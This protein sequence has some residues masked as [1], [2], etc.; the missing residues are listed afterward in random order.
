M[1]T[2]A[3]VVRKL[4]DPRAFAAA[5]LAR[6]LPAHPR[7]GH[8]WLHRPDGAVTFREHGFVAAD[9]P[10][11]LLVRHNYETERIRAELDGKR[12][13]RSL[14]LGCGFGR[15]SMTIAAFSDNHLAADI[16]EGA[17][18]LARS[19]YPH[20]NFQEVRP[21]DLPY[22][23]DQFDL[24][25]SWTVIQHVRPEKIAGVAAN[26][27]RIL[28]PGGTLLICEET[29]LAG[30]DGGHTWHRS[31]EDYRRLFSPLILVRHG[32]IDKL[33]RLSH[34]QSPGE[35]MLFELKPDV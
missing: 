10:A 30:H 32:S 4:R 26:M 29:R 7:Y 23:D 16:N 35:V 5:T 24:I 22:P 34:M 31:V 6:A 9:G 14:E 27:V 21:F 25:C 33:N 17:L 13:R 2:P 11:A 12:F 28:A 8:R 19:T 20:I 15:L 1:P 3:G 18:Q